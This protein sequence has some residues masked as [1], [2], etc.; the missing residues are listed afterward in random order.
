MAQPFRHPLDGRVRPH[1][2]ALH[3]P[4]SIALYPRAFVFISVMLSFTRFF[5]NALGIF[6]RTGKL[7]MAFVVAKSPRSFLWFSKTGG[8]TCKRTF[9]DLKLNQANI[10]L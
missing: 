5:T 3:V 6:P 8:R 7:M 1:G 2:L 9:G 4:D 10:P